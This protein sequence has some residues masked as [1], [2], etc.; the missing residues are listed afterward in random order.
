VTSRS[1]DDEA[2][3]IMPR[4]T[5]TIINSIREKPFEDSGG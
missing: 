1:L 2:A 5:I 4:I 3:M